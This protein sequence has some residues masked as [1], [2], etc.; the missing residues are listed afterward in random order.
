[1]KRLFIVM[2]MV[3]VIS[4]LV[5]PACAQPQTPPSTKP[6]PAPSPSPAPVIELR[7]GHQNP[8]TGRL[9]VKSINVWAKN[10]EE[11]TK[12]RVKITLYP[13]ESLFKGMEAWEAVTG[14]T[15]DIGWTIMGY[16]TGRF[17]LTSVMALPFLSLVSGKVDG[18]VRSGGAINSRILQEL[19]D[20]LPEM[21]A[22]WKEVKVMT[23]LC[24]DPSVLFTAKKPVRNMN[25]AKGLKL[26]EAGSYP[27]E[28]WKLLGA[29]PVTMGM[30]EAYDS[31]SKG[32][33]DGMNTTWSAIATFKLY[34]VLKYWSDVGTVASTQMTVMNLKTWNSLP[35]DIQQ[36]IMSVSGVKGAELFGDGGWGFDVK[37]EML[38]DATKAG[39]PMERVELDAGEYEKWKEVA[40]KPLWSKWVDEMKAKGLNGQKVLDATLALLKKYSP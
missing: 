14:G 18:K 17:P 9:T 6:T 29:S 23:M 39:K 15:T 3:V 24:S 1:M 32:V 19:Y 11:A 27:L 30:P 12:G 25:D 33:L 8:P 31:L 35:P 10:V 36:A 4:F 13:A 16:F 5:L 21:Q 38:A 2:L 37:E 34:E 26:R 40:G 22:E 7:F 20:T 28:M